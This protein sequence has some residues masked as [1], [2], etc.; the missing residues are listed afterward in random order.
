MNNIKLAIIF[1]FSFSFLSSESILND[2]SGAEV[3]EVY[4]EPF[5]I[6]EK[7]CR[8]NNMEACYKLGALYIMDYV[9]NTSDNKTLKQG[10]SYLDKSCTVG[11]AEGCT[12][13]AMIYAS[14]D[15]KQ[16]DNNKVVEYLDKACSANSIFGC[17]F[18]GKIYEDAKKQD[19]AKALTYYEKACNIGSDE[20]CAYA[21]IMYHDGK[22]VKQDFIKA[23]QMYRKSISINPKEP[24]SYMNI[25]ELQ[26]VQNIIFDKMLESKYVKYFKND[27]QSM[28]YYDM[29]KI[30]QLISKNRKVSLQKWHIKYKGIN[31]KNWDFNTLDAWANKTH[32]IKIKTNLLS[33]I[34][35]FKKH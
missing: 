31:T 1:L 25:F 6:Y 34:D 9:N 10:M 35:Q 30:L 20:A 29:L 13:L 22:K 7:A 28:M 17:V 12:S 23:E 21:G 24:S 19:F 4:T 5:Q 3:D 2:W 27:K 32:D 33:A 14:K 18:L 16:Q 26:L 11:Y 15:F 8:Y